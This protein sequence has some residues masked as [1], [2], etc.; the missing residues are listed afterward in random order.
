MQ[1]VDVGMGG[2]GFG[3]GG[4]F[5]SFFDG[6]LAQIGF[7]CSVKDSCFVVG[8]VVYL[9]NAC[10]CDGFEGGSHFKPSVTEAGGRGW[11]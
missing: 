11:A 10:A 2:E 1:G 9:A 7:G 4:G 5:V 3:S 6:A 8:I